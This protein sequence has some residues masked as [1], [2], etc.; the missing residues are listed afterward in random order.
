MKM[1]SPPAPLPTNLW[2]VP[3]EGRTVQ[4]IR[5]HDARKSFPLRLNSDLYQALEAWAQQELRSVNGQI[6]FLLREA[7]SK[8]QGKPLDA[9]SSATGKEEAGGN[10]LFGSSFVRRRAWRLQSPLT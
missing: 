10:R 8:R 5:P 9:A 3:G 6:E 7:V 4:K 2:S 1:P